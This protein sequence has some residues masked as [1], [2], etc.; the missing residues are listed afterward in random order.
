MH[1]L[2][3]SLSVAWHCGCYVPD[4]QPTSGVGQVQV[5]LVWGWLQRSWWTLPISVH[6]S[7]NNLSLAESCLREQV[8]CR[9]PWA[10]KTQR[11]DWK[12][13]KHLG[14]E[15]VIALPC[16]PF[17]HFCSSAELPPHVALFFLFLSS[18]NHQIC[19]ASAVLSLND[20]FHKVDS[21]KRRRT[22]QIF[23]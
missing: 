7:E 20:C 11:H 19:S 4:F 2:Q 8:T 22:W 12:P 13:S 21:R 6:V 3:M 1:R 15:D 9:G 23:Q 14:V 5:R 10:P 16:V 18:V 17:Q